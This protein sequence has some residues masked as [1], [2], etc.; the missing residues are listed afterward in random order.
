MLLQTATAALVSFRFNRACAPIS[1][2]QTF[3]LNTMTPTKQ[4]AP[5]EPAA[6]NATVCSTAYKAAYTSDH[7]N[8][9]TALL[10]DVTWSPLILAHKTRRAPTQPVLHMQ[11]SRHFLTRCR[12]A[13]G[14]TA[15][16]PSSQ[17][18]I[19]ADEPRV[20]VELP[21]GQVQLSLNSV[22]ATLLDLYH[23]LRLDATY[24]PGM[25]ELTAGRALLLPWFSCMP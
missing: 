18:R 19:A 20:I 6:F 15:L 14:P 5:C 10:P 2:L 1:W 22:A 17:E 4:G 13:A 25:H 12:V 7:D 11:K 21:D 23:E 3:S 16:C 24:L 8:L 9:A